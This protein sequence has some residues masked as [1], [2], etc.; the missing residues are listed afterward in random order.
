[1]DADAQKRFDLIT[2]NL[3]EVLNP[4]IIQGILAE[5]KNPRVYWFV[6]SSRAIKNR[7]LTMLQGN[8][9]DRPPPYRILPSCFKDCATPQG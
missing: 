8:S 6:N 3:A 7:R 2:S 9:D 1:M 4:E 5:G